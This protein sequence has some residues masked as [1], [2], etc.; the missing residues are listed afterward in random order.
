[1]SKV[2]SKIERVPAASAGYDVGR[3]KPP[4]ATRFAK[5]QSG[6]PSG[7]PKGARN[8]VPATNEERLKAIVLQEAYRDIKVNDGDRQI[9]IPM[10]QAVIR[11]IA[12]AAAKG[13]PR[14][15]VLFTT[16]LAAVEQERKALND[17]WLDGMI[18]YKLKWE[19]ELDRRKR[20]GL[21]LP[22]P[23]LH[24]DQVIIDLINGTALVR[25]SMT[26]EEEVLAGESRSL[27]EAKG[28]VCATA[29]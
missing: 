6:N 12:V 19:M 11:S 29:D 15:Q 5:G 10:A 23:V 7:K 3:G 26:A 9:T 8:R 21:E 27:A 13:Q 17:K 20:L 1:M 24:P 2:D 22:D 25:G 16:L 4:V 18:E 28:W 14:A